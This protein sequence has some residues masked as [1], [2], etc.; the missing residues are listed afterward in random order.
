MLS[1][2]PSRA[3]A[4]LEITGALG[5]ESPD[6]IKP[7]DVMRRTSQG[8][9]TLEEVFPHLAVERGALLEGRGPRRLQLAWDL[10]DGVVQ[11]SYVA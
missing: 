8:L 6:G 9:R 5:Y 11:T 10:D 7:S 3:Q 4:A 1:L 2:P